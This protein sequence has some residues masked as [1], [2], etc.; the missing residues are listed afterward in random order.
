M[1]NKNQILNLSQN[2]INQDFIKFE[3]LYKDFDKYTVPLKGGKYSKFVEISEID[4]SAN[5]DN[6]GG[7]KIGTSLE[8][9]NSDFLIYGAPGEN[10]NR[11]AVR[12]LIYSDVSQ[13]YES[14]D[15]STMIIDGTDPY[16]DV[17]EG[18]EYGTK[19]KYNPDLNILAIY[20]KKNRST[21]KGEI[22]FYFYDFNS[23][24][25]SFI[26]SFNLEGT[27]Y[28]DH[29][30]TEEFDFRSNYLA[31]SAEFLGF[32]DI[33][34]YYVEFNVGVLDMNFI[35]SGNVSAD[36]EEQLKQVKIYKDDIGEYGFISSKPDVNGIENNVGEIY[37][38]KWTQGGTDISNSLIYSVEIPSP[39][40]SFG[41][42]INIINYNL[43]D[44][45]I[46]GSNRG[47]GGFYIISDNNASPTGYIISGFKE[48]P[49]NTKN[50]G[51]AKQVYFYNNR[52]LYVNNFFPQ[53]STLKDGE[54]YHIYDI[55]S[56]NFL[57]N[58]N[59]NSYDF[60]SSNYTQSHEFGKSIGFLNDRVIISEPLTNNLRGS[61]YL[62]S[63][64]ENADI[65]DGYSSSVIKIGRYNN[66][67]PLKDK[68]NIYKSILIDKYDE[69]D[70]SQNIDD[71]TSNFTVNGQIAADRFIIKNLKNLESNEIRNKYLTFT[72][73]TGNFYRSSDIVEKI[74]SSNDNILNIST[75]NE[76]DPQNAD[77]NITGIVKSPKIYINTDKSPSFTRD[78]IYL[79]GSVKWTDFK[80][81]EDR[82][83]L[84]NIL[85]FSGTTGFME[86][87]PRS[88]VFN[89]LFK[90]ED[91][92]PLNENNQL[93]LNYGEDIN[94]ELKVRNQDTGITWKY[95]KFLNGEVPDINVKLHSYDYNESNYH[96][97]YL[98]LESNNDLGETE[99]IVS[100]FNNINNFS[101]Q[102][103]LLKIDENLFQIENLTFSDNSSISTDTFVENKLSISDKN[104]VHNGKPL[105]RI[106]TLENLGDLVGGYY[107]ANSVL[108]RGNRIVTKFRASKWNVGVIGFNTN[109]NAV[110][111]NSNQPRTT[112]SYF[113]YVN[114]QGYWEIVAY[115]S[116]G[117][118]N[119]TL[120]LLLVSTAI[121]E[122][123]EQYY[124]SEGSY[125]DAF[126]LDNY[127]NP[128]GG[129]DYE[130]F[131]VSDD[132]IINDTP[133]PNIR[134]IVETTQFEVP[135]GITSLKIE[136]QGPGG[137]GGSGKSKSNPIYE[138]GSG[139]GG[140]AG[141]YAKGDIDVVP[142]ELLTI[143]ITNTSTEIIRESDGTL[144][145]RTL[146]GGSGGGGGDTTNFIAGQLTSGSYVI[147]AG[148]TSVSGVAIGRGG[149]GGGGDYAAGGGGGGC[150][151]ASHIS[152][153]Q[154][155]V[156]RVGA[157]SSGYFV[158]KNGSIV[159]KGFNGGQGGSKRGDFSVG[160]FGGGASIS[161]AS[162]GTSSGGRG[163]NGARK[164][165]SQYGSGGQR[166]GG[167]GAGRAAGDN[168]D[169]GGGGGAGGFGRG[170]GAGGHAS[171][172]P[173]NGGSG[174][175]GGVSP[176][177]GGS[178][179]GNGNKRNGGNGASYGGGG[180]G[181]DSGSRGSGG[182]GIARVIFGPGRYYP[183]GDLSD[184]IVKYFA[185]RGASG[186][187]FF[188]NNDVMTNTV[189]LNG[190]A[191]GNGQYNRGNNIPTLAG[192]K[193]GSPRISGNEGRGGKGGSAGRATAFDGSEGLNGKV[194][195]TWFT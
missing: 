137:D 145:M 96:N 32:S 73:S 191:G 20:S 72:D 150:A 40:E 63:I 43:K 7:D 97:S 126:R 80:F 128:A 159:I 120:D 104:L 15:F 57:L 103:T 194:R 153:T 135:A 101:S 82:K 117:L 122:K 123:E 84:Q 31:L 162:G 105:I 51:F 165:D 171:G 54:G 164:D 10:V 170:G 88:E 22:Q 58:F 45:I 68:N 143:N 47:K 42:D 79:R 28:S 181:A 155:D 93:E 111:V 1:L 108:D 112:F 129:Y 81:V 139:G 189:G 16:A 109:S 131:G 154:G 30:I 6:N 146:K 39:F 119:Y 71:D 141:G 102:D 78:G 26:K 118:N 125:G 186:G 11:G 50:S 134:D 193:G 89:R 163:G 151:W 27:L 94:F 192:G 33:L 114:P 37:L 90:G 133:I 142:G 17:Q 24:G 86:K 188:V 99:F 13:S 100:K 25:F 178:R 75:D 144:L 121:S 113:S 70:L 195:I 147:P 184:Y 176:Y 161:N 115:T 52:F 107:E 168:G 56:E 3:S 9:I 19:I 175:G 185:G 169:A 67:I 152:V 61:L 46:A 138:A 85:A 76:A 187:G 127:D 53:G 87:V 182:A 36:T 157:D 136:S 44:Y 23:N 14:S 95:K 148:L 158:S 130:K 140:G 167:G 156:I 49:N 60:A 132:Q 174:G 21:Y 116:K 179:G 166:G 110:A 66:I 55:Q 41:R 77:F 35:F 83:K 29:Q 12:I 91:I 149:N 59:T 8:N 64:I 177:G 48:N 172:G 62:F 69:I 38:Y 180:G 98:S 106:V 34:S 190:N 124:G 2:K 5:S 65:L 92:N 4:L 160:G 173:S 74:I 18:D 183:N